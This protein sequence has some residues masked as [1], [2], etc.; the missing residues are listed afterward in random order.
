MLHAQQRPQRTTGAFALPLLWMYRESEEALHVLV[1]EQIARRQK[2]RYTGL[3]CAVA[4]VRKGFFRF[5]RMLYIV[6]T[7]W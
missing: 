2:R 6:K 3:Y 4:V 1:K 5:A 7:C